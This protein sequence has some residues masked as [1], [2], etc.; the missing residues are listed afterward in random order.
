MWVCAP[1]Q[2]SDL[3]AKFKNEKNRHEP[4][5]NSPPKIIRRALLLFQEFS[6][7]KVKKNPILVNI[8]IVLR[9]FVSVSTNNFIVKHSSARFRSQT[10]SDIILLF[11]SGHIVVRINYLNYCKR[12]GQYF[13]RQNSPFCDRCAV[14]IWCTFWGTP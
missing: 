4:Y 7:T 10:I 2:H 9:R 13:F 11:N 5:E 3:L 8:I 12:N 14:G 6:M 1:T